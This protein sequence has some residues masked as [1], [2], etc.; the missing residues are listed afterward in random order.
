MGG[1]GGIVGAHHLWHAAQG[2]QRRLHS[3]LESQEGLAGGDLGVAP[4]RVAE[5]QLEQQVGVGLASY[6]HSQ[7]IAVGEIKLG[8]PAPVDALGGS[9]PPDL[10]HST[11]AS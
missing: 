7:G 9:T 6:G 11:P 10:G 1:G 3:L 8:P 2:P 4:A 5:E